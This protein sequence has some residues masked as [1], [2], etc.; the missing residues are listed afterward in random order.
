MSVIFLLVHV[1]HFLNTK[2][3]ETAGDSTVQCPPLEIRVWGYLG[4]A[5]L[6]NSYTIPS[7]YYEI[8]YLEVVSGNVQAAGDSTNE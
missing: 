4:L 7:H 2:A 5:W 8:L 1:Q 6:E 3:Q